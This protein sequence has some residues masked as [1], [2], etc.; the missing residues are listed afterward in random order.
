MGI[1]ELIFFCDI[2]KMSNGNI[3]VSP[4]N[5]WPVTMTLTSNMAFLVE[6]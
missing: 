3:I 2:Y 6:N 4:S 1:S 5:N